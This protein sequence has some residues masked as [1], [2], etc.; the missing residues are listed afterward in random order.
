MKRGPDFVSWRDNN[1]ARGFAFFPESFLDLSG[2]QPYG[3]TIYNIDTKQDQILPQNKYHHHV[4]HRTTT[5]PFPLLVSN[6]R[7]NP[8][9]TPLTIPHKLFSNHPIPY[10]RPFRIVLTNEAP[11]AAHHFNPC[12]INSP[13]WARPTQAA[14][15]PVPISPKMSNLAKVGA[16]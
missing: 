1:R 5:S 7:H 11:C 4:H 16:Q 15:T 10:Q 8:P 14:Y 13:S 2:S 12:T 9:A 6:H 3:Q